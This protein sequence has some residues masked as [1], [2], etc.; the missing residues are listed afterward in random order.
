MSKYSLLE[1]SM[2]VLPLQQL[3]PAPLPHIL[4]TWN[5]LGHT[6]RFRNQPLKLLTDVRKQCG[7]V[8]RVWMGSRWLTLLSHPTGVQRVLVE[9]ASHYSKQTRGAALLRGL[10][11]QGLLTAEGDYWKRQRRIAQPAFVPQKVAGLA[12]VMQQAGQ[13]L[14]DSWEKESEVDVAH[15]LNRLTL[16]IAGE[17]LFSMDISKESSEIGQALD[18]VLGGFLTA[19]TN[20]VAPYLPLPSTLRYRAGIK[21]LDR[22]VREIIARRR[23]DTVEHNDLLGMF[24]GARDQ[25]TGEGMSD[26]QLRDEVL[27]MLLAGHETTA[28]A[29]A[30]T[31]YRLALHPEHQDG[32]EDRLEPVLKES[33]RLH[34][35]V[36]ILARRAEAEDIIGGYRIPDKS[37]V[38]VSPY[39][40][41]RHPEFW[42]NPERFDPSRF[43]GPAARERNRFAWF[44][45]GAGPRRCIGEHFAMVEAKMILA[46][47][48]D[49]FRFILP[50]GSKVEGDPSVTLRPKG[51]LSLKLERKSL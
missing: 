41:H 2:E 18:G 3:A 16:R 17:T 20:P 37:F 1:I 19:L 4:P 38:F 9:G 42:P 43:E 45:F 25:E 6:L 23:K 47:L 13:D 8:G 29:L 51:G 44:P 10:L 48:T 39:I 24:M 27:T 33:L 46:I 26:D 14:A 11:G 30:W 32:I 22:V 5:P 40:T 49:R 35:P 7:D 50:E 36:W 28:N 34:P 31:L 21:T 15:A 12:L